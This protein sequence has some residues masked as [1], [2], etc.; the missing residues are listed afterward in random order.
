MEIFTQFKC[1]VPL[2]GSAGEAT[3]ESWIFA[4]PVGREFWDGKRLRT[5]S[6]EEAQVY[7]SN[8]RAAMSFFDKSAPDGGTPYRFPI[9]EDH[10]EGK[11][12]GDILDV[13]IAG[14]GDWFGI[15]VKAGW[16][17]TTWEEI[18]ASNRKHVSIAIRGFELEDGT[19]LGPTIVE[20][21]LTEDPRLQSIGTIQDT[22]DIKLSRTEA[23]ETE[24]SMDEELKALLAK[25]AEGQAQILAALQATEA[26]Q[27]SDDE[28]EDEEQKNA[29]ASGEG[30]E[31]KKEEAKLSQGGAFDFDGFA[32][33]ITSAV[34]TGVAEAM[35]ET[36]GRVGSGQPH[37]TEQGNSNGPSPQPPTSYEGLRD[38]YLSQGMSLRDASR[39]AVSEFRT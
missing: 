14:E 11:R 7:L 13:K 9:K 31:K 15:W 19:Q 37:T 26:N 39:K 4:L 24:E 32:A 33:S 1:A 28:E 6:E 22:L 38:F 21:S 36:S 29:G 23:G 30:G 16:N 18:A 2:K 5:V 3:T 8:T 10:K 27:N 35:K 25:I 34:K 17:K 12:Y 20:T